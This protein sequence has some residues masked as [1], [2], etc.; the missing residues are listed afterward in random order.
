MGN[1]SRGNGKHRGRYLYESIAVSELVMVPLECRRLDTKLGHGR[2]TPG[3]VCVLHD[4]DMACQHWDNGLRGPLAEVS[5]AQSHQR[6]E[7]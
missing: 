6:M 2:L 1:P 5:L 7:M 4:G 3:S